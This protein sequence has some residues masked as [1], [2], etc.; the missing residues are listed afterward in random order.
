VSGTGSDYGV[1]RLEDDVL[2]YSPD[3]V[4]VEFAVNDG[5]LAP[6]LIKKTFEGI[7][8]K[9][10]KKNADTDICFVYTVN[11][12]SM[13]VYRESAWP[14]MQM[15]AAAQ[16]EVAEY[17]Q[18]PSINFAYVV[19]DLEKEG[20]LIF[21]AAKE[22]KGKIVFSSDGTHPKANGDQLYAGAVVRAFSELEKMLESAKPHVIP[23]ALSADNWDKACAIGPGEIKASGNWEILTANASSKNYN[24]SNAQLVGRYSG[25]I[26]KL[27]PQILRTSHPGDSF[28]LKFKGTA[29]GL[30]EVGGPWSGFTSVSIDGGAPQ[31]FNRFSPYNSYMRQQYFYLPEMVQGEYVVQFILSEGIPDKKTLLTDKGSVEKSRG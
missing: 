8:R 3:L 20:K 23:V 26:K 31:K 2:R 1:A 19:A 24:E 27:C 30:M 12:S 14:T 18:V 9:I 21:R 5:G 28:T 10:W 25:L 6:E 15:S 13:K 22:E 29:V 4:L 17:Y 11:E 16:E 7:V